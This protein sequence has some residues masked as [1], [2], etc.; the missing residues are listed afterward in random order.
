M[1][2]IFS[3]E[4]KIE[5]LR[6]EFGD[7]AF[8]KDGNVKKGKLNWLNRKLDKIADEL[9]VIID[10][11]I[12]AEESDFEFVMDDRPIQDIIMGHIE[13]SITQ[14]RVYYE[15]IV[16]KENVLDMM[17]SENRKNARAAAL[18]L[19][20]KLTDKFDSAY[21]ERFLIPSMTAA[22]SAKRGYFFADKGFNGIEQVRKLFGTTKGDTGKYSKPPSYYMAGNLDNK[23]VKRA[24]DNQAGII[25][26]QQENNKAFREIV[27][28]LKD[29]VAKGDIKLSE[30]T[31]ILQVMNANQKG[32]TRTSAILDFL[33]TNEFELIPQF[34]K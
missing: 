10:P 13:D 23:G 18:K 24:K 3:E 5:L 25:K 16:G 6:E 15:T 22:F 31:A 12:K 33:P 27:E 9:Q 29:M 19:G 34:N 21:V 4:D 11:Y 14:N 26:A 7:E 32:L 30:A 28:I 8:D 2:G 1:R 17:D 20:V